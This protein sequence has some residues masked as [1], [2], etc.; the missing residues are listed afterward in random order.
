MVIIGV[1]QRAVDAKENTERAEIVENARLDVLAQ[2]TDNKGN[3]ITESQLKSVLEKYFRNNEIPEELPADLSTLELTTLKNEK[4]K[5]KVSE[6]Y[7]GSFLK[8]SSSTVLAKDKLLINLSAENDYEKGPYVNY[9][10]SKGT[11]LCRTIY[12]DATNG[13]QIISVNSVTNVKLGIEDKYVDESITDNY[14]RAENSYQNAIVHLNKYSEEYL[15]TNNIADDVR[16]VGSNPIDKNSNITNTDDEITRL[17]DLNTYDLTGNNDRYWLAKTFSMS[18]PGF[19]M[20]GV[21]TA[22]YSPVSL[23]QTQVNGQTAQTTPYTRENG[24]RPVFIL[25]ESVRILSGEGTID[26]PYEIG[27]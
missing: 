21:I 26:S 20:S 22:P 10:S 24:L 23:F 8:N 27:R 14:S 18:T 7:D 12:N 11:I 17:T 9:P 16:C 4:Y 3:D 15:D 19:G 2:I 25:N 1:L 6:I 13:V 5:I